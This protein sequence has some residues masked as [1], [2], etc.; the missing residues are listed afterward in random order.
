MKRLEFGF[1]R[2]LALVIAMAVMLGASASAATITFSQDT[3]TLFNNEWSISNN[4]SN[5]ITISASGLT[6]I[7][8]G[9]TFTFL[10]GLAGLT[11][12]FTL[13]AV[14]S[15]AGNC[16]NTCATND[17]YNENGYAGSFSFL[18]TAQDQ[19]LYGIPVGTLLLGGTLNTTLGQHGATFSSSAGNGSATFQDSTDPVNTTQLVFSSAYINFTFQTAENASFA[20]SSLTPALALTSPQPPGCGPAP[21]AQCT[22]FPSGTTTAAGAGTF[23]TQPGFSPEPGSAVLI[24]IGLCGLTVVARRRRSAPK[25]S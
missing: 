25:C 1:L 7:A 11:A 24:G 16:N 23:A 18:S 22:A 9:N 21:L 3:Q 5:T 2:R 20:L 4:G 15:T 6:N 8:F 17:P 10:D 12:Q 19:T 14:S 13:N